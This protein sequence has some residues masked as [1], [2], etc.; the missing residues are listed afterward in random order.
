M[1]YPVACAICHAMNGNKTE[2]YHTLDCINEFHNLYETEIIT[3]SNSSSMTEGDVC[4]DELFLID[5]YRQ[6]MGWLTFLLYNIF[7]QL[8][9]FHDTM[10]V[11]DLPEEFNLKAKG[12]YATIGLQLMKF[13]YGSDRSIDLSLNESKQF[14]NDLMHTEIDELLEVAAVASAAA[15]KPRRG[16]G[17]ERRS[18]LRRTI[19]RR[20]SVSNEMVAEV[21]RRMAQINVQQE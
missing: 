19:G 15:N 13:A 20:V 6:T 4:S 16:G 7:Y 14:F 17:G 12:S 8:N 9:I 5:L 10:P 3:Q 21:Q 2:A 18:S 11:Q 1:S